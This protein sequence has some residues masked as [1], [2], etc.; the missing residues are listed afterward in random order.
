MAKIRIPKSGAAIGPQGDFFKDRTPSSGEFVSAG[1]EQLGSSLL[2][3]AQSEAEREDRNLLLSNPIEDIFTDSAMENMQMVVYDENGEVDFE[4]TILKAENVIESEEALFGM[5]IQNAASRIEQLPFRSNKVKQAA[6]AQLQGIAAKQGSSSQR[7]E[8]LRGI[9]D[10]IKLGEIKN[11]VFDFA[12]DPDDQSINSLFDGVVDISETMTSDSEAKSFILKE[13]GNILASASRSFTGSM[14]MIAGFESE[15]LNSLSARYQSTALNT[16]NSTLGMIPAPNKMTDEE[17]KISPSFS[18]VDFDAMEEMAQ[19]IL[20]LDDG[21]GKTRLQSLLNS[22]VVRSQI[23]SKYGANLM[24][25]SNGNPESASIRLNPAEFDNYISSSGLYKTDDP[26]VL[27]SLL[28]YWKNSTNVFPKNAKKALHDF[29]NKQSYTQEEQP[30][31]RYFSSKRN[32]YGPSLTDEQRERLDNFS[33]RT[34]TFQQRLEVV[35]TVEKETLEKISNYNEEYRV[36]HGETSWLN[37]DLQ[38]LLNT[39]NIKIEIESDDNEIV[40]DTFNAYVDEA[41]NEMVAED[42]SILPS[43]GQVRQRALAKFMDQTRFIKLEDGT[44]KFVPFGLSQSFVAEGG[45][46]VNMTDEH[47]RNYLLQKIKDSPGVRGKAKSREQINSLSQKILKR[48]VLR[49]VD[50]SMGIY[51]LYDL[52][53]PDSPVISN[54]DAT[55]M[56]LDF[57]DEDHLISAEDLEQVKSWYWYQSTR[58][59]EM[60]RVTLPNELAA[61]LPTTNQFKDFD[62]WDVITGSGLEMQSDVDSWPL[63]DRFGPFLET[64]EFQSKSVE[65]K[66]A[67]MS[68]IGKDAKRLSQIDPMISHPMLQGFLRDAFISVHREVFEKRLTT[69]GLYE[70]WHKDEAKDVQGNFVGTNTWFFK[71][72]ILDKAGELYSAYLNSLTPEQRKA[73]HEELTTTHIVPSDMIQSF[74]MADVVRRKGETEVGGQSDIYDAVYQMQRQRETERSAE[75]S[76]DVNPPQNFAP[77]AYYIE[78]N[79][80]DYL[81][82]TAKPLPF[83]LK[84]ILDVSKPSDILNSIRGTMEM[85]SPEVYS[86]EFLMDTLRLLVADVFPDQS[87]QQKSIYGIPNEELLDFVWYLNKED[88]DNE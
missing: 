26:E 56:Q 59:N 86:D 78:N 20:T 67:F 48:S 57:V 84:N 21:E 53:N 1:L 32:E 69:K 25:I 70:G 33:R 71:N 85:G 80:A 10:E 50:S 36:V 39:A 77:Y 44:D 62:Q 13:S 88:G 75:S 52:D 38:Q 15:T 12:L 23:N 58:Q 18:P 30:L 61:Y 55:E 37:V 29:L 16:I 7:K 65:E 19:Y 9:L 34:G 73:Y 81:K 17:R 11:R 14:E 64:K 22:A 79:P 5:S 82:N 66:I 31:F 8:R 51:A 76:I 28:L 60:S 3:Y 83:E 42:P 41:F 63:A 27:E 4:N 43:G 46:T 40:R 45:Q 68:Q 74:D 47:I 2:K 35:P 54:F 72:Q 49:A 24:L 87:I 6:L